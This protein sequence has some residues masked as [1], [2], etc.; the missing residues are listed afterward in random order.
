MPVR[1]IVC[2]SCHGMGFRVMHD[3]DCYT[4]DGS[5]TVSVPA[6]LQPDL[7]PETLLSYEVISETMEAS[8][9]V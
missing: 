2:P 6:S 5:G 8:H 9:I 4:C 7:F 1:R 3:S